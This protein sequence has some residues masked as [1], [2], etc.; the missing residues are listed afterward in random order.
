MPDWPEHS[1][2]AYL[3]RLPTQTLEMLAAQSPA[4]LEAQLTPD[5]IDFLQ[6]ILRDRRKEETYTA[7]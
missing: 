6:A 1:V 7:K 3:T 2:R 4:S 5:E